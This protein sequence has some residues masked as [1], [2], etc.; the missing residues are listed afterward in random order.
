LAEV[1]R[2][3]ADLRKMEKVLRRMVAQCDDKLIPECPIIDAL[4]A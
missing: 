2:R 4:F 1:K 3:L